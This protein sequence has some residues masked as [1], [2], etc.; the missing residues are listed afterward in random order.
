MER[1]WCEVYFKGTETWS[2]WTERVK[3]KVDWG[4]LVYIKDTRRQVGFKE[5]EQDKY[6]KGAGGEKWI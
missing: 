6:F 4:S 5:E 1:G 2:K 3:K